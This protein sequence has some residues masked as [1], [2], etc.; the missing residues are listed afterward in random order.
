[1]RKKTWKNKVVKFVAAAFAV[2]TMLSGTMLTAF[3]AEPDPKPP[4]NGEKI[5]MKDPFDSD[6][7]A[8][9]F[10]VKNSHGH[11]LELI[12]G[13]WH[14]NNTERSADVYIDH[15]QGACFN[16]TYYDVREY[17]WSV[18]CEDYWITS[19]GGGNA[20]GTEN[21]QIHRE[22]H[23]YEEGTL[24]SANPV[25]TSFKGVMR[26]TDL[27][28]EEGYT[29]DQGLY[30]AWL[31]D[32]TN[33][34]KRDA[35]TWKG[36][37]QNNNDGVDAEREML[38]VEIEGSPQKPFKLTYWVNAK[39]GSDI[40]Y[41]GNTVKY[42]LVQT[43]NKLPEGATPRVGV[44]C[45]TYAK[46]DLMPNDEFR[47]YEF[48]G[49]Y[50]DKELTKKVPDTIMVKEDHTFYGT[51]VKV[52]GIITTEV[53]N[54]TITPV[55]DYVPYGT[56][57]VIDYQPNEGHILD[58]ITVDGKEVSLKDFPKQFAFNNVQ[59]DHHI[60]VVYV[61]PEMEKAV[62]MKESDFIDSYSADQEVDGLVIK[63]GDVLTYKIFYTNPGTKVRDIR[64]QDALPGGAEVI[65]GSISGNGKLADGKITWNIKA[66]PNEEGAVSFDCKVLE[67][68]EGST[69]KNAATVTYPNPGYDNHTI[70]DEVTTP[71][72]PTPVKDVVSKPDGASIN[73]FP[74][75]VGETIYYT[76]RFK[77]P[78]EVEKTVT[79]KDILPQG[80]SFVSADKDGRYD[81][82]EHSVS[83]SYA[84]AP[85]AGEVLVIKCKVLPKAQSTELANKAMVGMDKV[86]LDS[87]TDNGGEDDDTTRN[88]IPQKFV[89][90]ADGNDID[91]KEVKAGDIVTY[92]ISYKNPARQT[93]IIRI[94][95]TLPQGV[96]YIDG[97]DNSYVKSIVHGQSVSWELEAKPGQEGTVAVSV[98]VTD[99]LKGLAFA[100]SASV[101]MIDPE[102]G[103]KKIVGTNQVR[104]T[105]AEDEPEKDPE[106]PADPEKKDDDPKEPVIDRDPKETDPKE[107]DKKEDPKVTE[108]PKKDEQ[109]TEDKKEDQK[110]EETKTEDK[111]TITPTSVP[112][113]GTGSSTGTPYTGTTSPGTTTPQTVSSQP[114]TGT[115][116]T[117]P[118][119]TP[120]VPSYSSGKVGSTPQTGDASNM[121]LWG[122]LTLL[123]GGGAAGYGG[124]TIYKRRK[125]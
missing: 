14:G 2:A 59:D 71:V 16:G 24:A 90:D 111:K 56:D 1:M 69:F 94:F 23:F 68:A 97:T 102:S 17:V 28:I 18:E 64:I 76:I 109:K 96:I 54:G 84:V 48:D 87:V 52:A 72:L 12:D 10:C 25:E 62:Y 7:S 36:T 3:A 112:P 61:K 77:N 117:T 44:H 80:V 6:H 15:Y 40:N 4:A 78:A 41:Y 22:F 30:A 46:Y 43:K 116:V 125:K 55:E 26:L 121:I 63:E 11:G 82:A 27:D 99:D 88:Y 95:D 34:T 37:W 104:N 118:Q 81:N 53:V 85:G 79:V 31:N 89:F 115:T 122:I 13:Y 119:S 124:Y 114:S 83:W 45:A 110:S 73:T 70:G 98:R 50:Y 32:P 74:V 75:K 107:D 33:V 93:R 57:K 120:T 49:W 113:T 19:R 91:G 20:I 38:W 65:A 92:K 100:N 67:A 103:E 29:F 5:Y 42:Q 60:K 123:S 101:E 86:I 106:E 21:A 108:K 66:Q 47:Y 105:V 8:G 39:H 58:S 35:K 9:Y 51:Y